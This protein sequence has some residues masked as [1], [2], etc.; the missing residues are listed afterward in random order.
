MKRRK[1]KNLRPGILIPAFLILFILNI[2]VSAQTYPTKFPCINHLNAYGGGFFSMAVDPTDSNI[3]YLGSG[4]SLYK[5]NNQ[6]STW[7]KLNLIPK[8][9]SIYAIAINPANP[10][11]IYVGTE[12][13]GAYKSIDAGSSWTQIFP[14]E[15]TI[16]ITRTIA[17]DL[18]NPDTV[19]IGASNGSLYQG[20]YKSTDGGNSWVQKN[21]GLDI[22][23]SAYSLT[24]DPNNSNII[25]LATANSTF[26]I[27]KSIDA[28]E[29]WARSY[30][31]I[32]PVD[33]G[34]GKVE[35]D[36][37]DS[38]TLYAAALWE[39]YKSTDAGQNWM[40]LDIQSK[41]S[42]FL[43]IETM[44]MDPN[45]PQVLYL[46]TYE[47]W[48][49]KT[50]DGGNTWQKVNPGL[51]NFATV[52]YIEVDSSSTVYTG[53]DGHSLKSLN[54]GDSWIVIDKYI[55]EFSFSDQQHFSNLKIAPS[56]QQIIFAGGSRGILKSNDRGDSWEAKKTVNFQP[57]GT[58]VAI[59]PL[60]SNIVFAS[61][62]QSGSSF[63]YI[64]DIYKS[65]NG[66]DTWE[67]KDDS[68]L[69][70]WV[71]SIAVSSSDP[72]IYYAS[73]HGCAIYKSI[74]GGETWILNKP[75]AEGWCYHALD[76][77]IHPLNSDIVYLG[78]ESH[79]A[80]VPVET[81]IWKTDDGGNT[82]IKSSNGLPKLTT[83]AG[84]QAECSVPKL[85]IDPTNPNTIYAGI[86]LGGELMHG[87]GCWGVFK[88][89]DGGINWSRATK[90]FGHGLLEDYVYDLVMDPNNQN[91]IYAGTARESVYVS[92]DGAWTWEEIPLGIE[93]LNES[94]PSLAFAN[95]SPQNLYIGT[96]E[97]G[98]FRV[99]IPPTPGSRP[100]AYCQCPGE[101][102]VYPTYPE[103]LWES[104][105]WYLTGNR[106]T[107]FADY[108][109]GNP[110]DFDRVLFQYRPYDNIVN[111]NN[112]DIPWQDIP[113]AD[114]AHPN[115][116]TT[117]PYF[118][119]FDLTGLD[120]SI[121]FF[122]LRAIG[123]HK[124][125][126]EDHWV[127][128]SPFDLDHTWP[129][130]KQFVNPSNEL[131]VRKTFWQGQWVWQGEWVLV[132]AQNRLLVGNPD[133]DSY[134]ELFLQGDAL[135]SDTTLTYI[136]E[137]P[138]DH[139]GKV[140][141]GQYQSLGEFRSVS[142]DSGQIN[143][144]NGRLSTV[145]IG[146][147]DSNQDGTVD[148]TGISESSLKV[149]RF[150]SGTTWEELT[151]TVLSDTNQVETQVSK[152][153]LFALFGPVP[154]PP[155]SSGGGAPSGCGACG[156]PQ[157][158]QLSTTETKGTDIDISLVLLPLFLILF[159]RRFQRKTGRFN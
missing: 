19:Y 61:G 41:V 60:D 137:N 54:G 55:R 57:N 97:E 50:S 148:G 62:S 35:V 22:L 13:K 131:E 27:Y 14:G 154:P 111:P 156:L 52:F 139:E 70:A 56:N 72:L 73:Y 110:S 37:T 18:A 4:L 77:A 83:D 75:G 51:S 99:T 48:V 76:I 58:E 69:I 26:P 78:Y 106:F 126:T 33:G 104:P 2:R 82:W 132:E 105:T 66:G 80:D 90:P 31:G 21:N 109:C 85:L 53:S 47:D 134:D 59:S 142:L 11:I 155:S 29:T 118:V 153:S 123:Y 157:C 138:S 121:N 143:F 6:G 96:N 159:S 140:D 108:L 113:A 10:A 67:G 87:S 36:P 147:P 152:F 127:L 98:I 112:W 32:D 89:T 120:E 49:M 84:P 63:I 43:S 122:E 16:G 135:S 146:Y 144:L 119:H 46:G 91:T 125:G 24:I 20:V 40:S 1:K 88:S 145:R 141:S 23:T 15:D 94:T 102:R 115:P 86:G 9:T 74:D 45:N 42:F 5:S 8:F 39:V 25:Y 44:A 79:T 114:P 100:C 28:G 124:D 101:A 117:Y 7:E 38:N 107:V 65:L 92:F 3:L 158:R 129:D 95:T 17:I 64:Y 133:K 71:F 81:G 149:Y 151:S 116:D 128:R 68:P 12:F 103:N 93:Y 34:V 30:T 136:V 150:V 130:E